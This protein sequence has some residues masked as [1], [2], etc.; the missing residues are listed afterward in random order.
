VLISLVAHD[1]W[2]GAF[3]GTLLFLGREH[4]QAEYWWIEVCGHGRR[5]EM[6]LWAAL[7]CVFEIAAFSGLRSPP[8]R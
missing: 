6:P 2:S 4:A 5:K 1:L 8:S 7:T 3:A